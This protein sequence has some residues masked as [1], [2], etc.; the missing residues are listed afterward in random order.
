MFYARY[1]Q[2]RITGGRPPSFLVLTASR[3]YLLV[4]TRVSG[5]VLRNSCCSSCIP[6]PQLI[7]FRKRLSRSP[8]EFLHRRETVLLVFRGW[9]PQSTKVYAG[10]PPPV[11]RP[12][13]LQNLDAGS[14]PAASP[15]SAFPCHVKKE[16]ERAVATNLLRAV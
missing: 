10:H 14:P 13:K 8:S 7:S 3:A 1:L 12:F 9:V 6:Y 15:E 4:R 16:R 11:T 5:M 2:L